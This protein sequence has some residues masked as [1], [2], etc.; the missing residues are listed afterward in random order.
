MEGNGWL[1]LRKRRVMNVEK[2]A[3]EM[4]ES[5]RERKF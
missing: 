2:N 1:R 3:E 4:R 5:E